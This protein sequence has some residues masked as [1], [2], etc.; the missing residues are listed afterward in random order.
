[1]AFGELGEEIESIYLKYLNHLKVSIKLYGLLQNLTYLDILLS[2]SKNL[3][4][5]A[6]ALVG[7]YPS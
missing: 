6:A 5:Q 2:P 3:S 1:M 7:L 4:K